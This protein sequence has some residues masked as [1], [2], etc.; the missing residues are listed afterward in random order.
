MVKVFN[1][2][3]PGYELVKVKLQWTIHI[4]L[5][6]TKDGKSQTLKSP[7]FSPQETPNSKWVLLV[8][9]T[10]TQITI[11]PYH[12][13]SAGELEDLVEP[14][15]MKM[16]ILNKRGEKVLQ[17][18]VSSAPNSCDVVFAI[19]QGDLIKCQQ[20]DG[21]LIFN[22]K[23]ITHLKK[24]SITISSADPSVFSVDCSGGLSTHLDR[25]FNSMQFSDVN[26]TIR[27]REFPAHKNIL[28]TR[29]EVFAAMFQHPTK[30]QLT[31]QIKIEDIEP[32][33]FQELL[34][35]IYT[36]RLSI[37][38]METIATG[39]FIAADKYLLDELKMRCEKYLVLHM[40]PD[41]CVLLLLHGDLLNPAE[42]FKKAVKF[43]RRFPKEVMATDGWKKMKQEN[44]VL[45][46]GIQELSLCFY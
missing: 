6:H 8:H 9:N 26:F 10:Q 42:P 30:E 16:S 29:S 3:R 27:G 39:L 2:F 43:L 34:R 20:S 24:E 38:S 25:L 41:I 28:A 19:S 31:N 37:T 13:D 12:S 33:V 5:L 23:I 35:F 14:V 7:V 1:W 17:V 36:G 4:P 21:S 22:C 15:L 46:C 18:M 32:D 44:P 11:R 45:L 40:S